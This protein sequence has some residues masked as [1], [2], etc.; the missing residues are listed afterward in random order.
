MG[1]NISSICY[2]LTS[3]KSRWCL[4]R[5]QSDIDRK[6]QIRREARGIQFSSCAKLRSIVH[7]SGPGLGQA[8]RGNSIATTKLMIE[9]QAQEEFALKEKPSE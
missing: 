3:T 5:R 1:A 4:M 7:C 2:S 8:G 6:A 9:K